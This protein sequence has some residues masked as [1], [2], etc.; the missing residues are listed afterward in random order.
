M[1]D[2]P[3]LLGV[4]SIVGNDD[5]C[6]TQDDENN[7]QDDKYDKK[8]KNNKTDVNMIKLINDKGARNMIRTIKT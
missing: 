8:N 5:I 1:I 6:N 4:L 2:R 7:E 3:R